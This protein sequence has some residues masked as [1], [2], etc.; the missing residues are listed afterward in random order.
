MRAE[1][2][3]EDMLYSKHNLF[4]CTDIYVV[5]CIVFWDL[6]IPTKN[7][8]SWQ[9]LGEFKFVWLFILILT[10][11]WNQ[12]CHMYLNKL[13]AKGKRI[14]ETFYYEFEAVN[15]FSLKGCK[16]ETFSSKS[17]AVNKFSEVRCEF[18]IYYI[19]VLRK[20]SCCWQYK[21]NANQ[22]QLISTNCTGCRWRN[23]SRGWWTLIGI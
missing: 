17:V 2:G 10:W 8:P 5:L 23:W 6:S 9:L 1:K 4:Y 16:F 18:D 20:R 22:L 14:F 13:V 21:L 15:K 7:P 19:G 11:I 12:T 3:F